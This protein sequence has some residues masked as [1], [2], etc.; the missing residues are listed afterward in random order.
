MIGRWINKGLG[1]CSD[2]NEHRLFD[3]YIDGN[4]ERCKEKCLDFSNECKFI[5][6]GWENSKW[7]TGISSG[8]SCVTRDQGPTD[9]GSSGQNGVQSYE[10]IPGMKK[11]H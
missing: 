2:Y 10:Y 7:C 1:C 9:C 3:G 11:V 6:Y 5:L 8:A 4:L